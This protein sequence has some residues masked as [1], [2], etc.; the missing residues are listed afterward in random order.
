MSMTM[1]MSL[2][3]GT[4]DRA[5]AVMSTEMQDDVICRGGRIGTAEDGTGAKS[6]DG[7]C[8]GFGEDSTARLSEALPNVPPLG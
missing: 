5:C 3:T 8:E 1:Y 6:E 4:A 7:R 2:R